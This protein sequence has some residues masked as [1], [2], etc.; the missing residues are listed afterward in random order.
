[1]L[2]VIFASSLD[3]FLASLSFS[4]SLS[5][6]TSLESSLFF[7]CSLKSFGSSPFRA[8]AHASNGRSRAGVCVASNSSFAFRSKCDGQVELAAGFD[9]APLPS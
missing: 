5:Q 9:L 4:L 8:P 2:R 7:V 6:S 3:A 1:M